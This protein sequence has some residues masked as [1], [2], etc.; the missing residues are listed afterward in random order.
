MSTGKKLGL[1]VLA[2]AVM[3]VPTSASAQ[4]Q[5]LCTR[6]LNSGTVVCPEQHQRAY[7]PTGPAQPQYQPPV[8]VEQPSPAATFFTSLAAGVVGVVVGNAIANRGHHHSSPGY[9]GGPRY[10]A[11]AD[12][13]HFDNNPWSPNYGHCVTQRGSVRVCR[14]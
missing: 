7:T 13:P 8:V 1:A 3:A 6:D 5:V 11:P 10:V 2:S 14:P 4:Q 9:V 12:I